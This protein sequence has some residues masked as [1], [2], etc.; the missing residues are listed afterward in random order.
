MQRDPRIERR[1][2]YVARAF[3]LVYPAIQKL[4]FAP[5]ELEFAPKAIAPPER[6]ELMTRHGRMEALVFSPTREDLAAQRARGD[7]APVHLLTHGGAFILQYP[8]EEGNVARYLAATVGCV[9]VIPDYAAAPQACFPV[10]EEQCFDAL[11]WIREVADRHGWDRDRITVGGPSAGGKLA[12]SVALA[13]IDA[14]GFV[15]LAVTSEYGCADIGRSDAER[16]SAKRFPVVG[17][18]L[19]RLVRSTYYVGCDLRSPQVSPLY[20]PRLS[21]MPPTLIMT[22]EFDTLRHESNDLA[23]ELERRGVAVTHREFP[24]VDHGFTHQKPVETARAAVT[25]IARHLH[26]AFDGALRQT[27]TRSPRLV[28]IRNFQP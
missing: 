19:M 20:H 15:P 1:H 5:S 13:A 11:L 24:R 21:E 27:E 7:L 9:V 14:G 8:R 26:T 16:T 3:Q 25:M 23:V 17:P 28:R 10:A 12:L 2:A 4:F 18:A 22:A 6:L